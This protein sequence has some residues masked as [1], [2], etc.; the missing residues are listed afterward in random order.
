[1]TLGEMSEKV[2]DYDSDVGGLSEKATDSRIPL[3]SQ[4]VW[5]LSWIEQQPS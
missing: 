1:M 2:G 5:L 4:M 3:H